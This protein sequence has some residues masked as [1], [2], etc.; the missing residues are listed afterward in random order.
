MVVVTKERIE[1]YAHGEF[2]MLAFL[3][4]LEVGGIGLTKS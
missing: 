2:S 1:H 3:P 4:V